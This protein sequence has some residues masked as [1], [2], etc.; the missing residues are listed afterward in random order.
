MAAGAFEGWM[1]V[2]RAARALPAAFFI[3]ELALAFFFAICTGW[4]RR[5]TA[6]CGDRAAD[7][8]CRPAT[9]VKTSAMSATNLM[10]GRRSASGFLER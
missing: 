10:T 3:F 5:A 4:W 9:V 6:G 1:Y 2:P 7:G 8:T